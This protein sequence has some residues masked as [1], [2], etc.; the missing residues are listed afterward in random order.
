MNNPMDEFIGDL[1]KQ[2]EAM[3]N[4]RSTWETH[5]RE[6]ADYVFPRGND[7]Q[8][9]RSQGDKRNQK[10]FDSTA[11]LACNRFAAA[12]ESLLTPRA[13]KWHSLKAT[14][15][16]LNMNF[17]VQKW[18]DEAR[19][20]L[21]EKRYSPKANFASQIYECWMS[22][23]SFG[24]AALFVDED[25]E[26]MGIRY[27]AVHL[28]D[29][30]VKENFAGF[31][32]VLHREF[33]LTARQATQNFNKM[34]DN[35]PEKI[36]KCAKDRPDEKFKFIH[37]VKPRADAIYGDLTF[38]GM[39]Y[40]S[41]Y[42]CVSEK[43]MVREGG[44]RT[45]PYAI[46]R[47]NVAPNE[48]YGRSPAMDV[49]PDIK[50][51]NE[52]EKTT[53]RAAHKSVDPPL[54][55]HDDGIL[56]NF[57]ARPGALN[58]GGVDKNGRQ[59]VTPMQTGAN[60]PLVED[61]KNKKRETINQAF[62]VTLFQILVD[63]PR[64]TATEAQIRNQEKGALLSPTMGRQQSEGLGP[65]IERELEIL[66]NLNVLPEVPDMLAET[67]GQYQVQYDSTLT[68]LQRSEETVG[69]QMM[70]NDLMPFAQQDPTVLDVINK[71]ELA[72]VSSEVNGV[73]Y[74][75]LRSPE[76]VDQM[77][78]QRAQAAEQAAQQAAVPE[79]AGAAKDMAAANK[80]NAEAKAA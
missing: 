38:R 1:I 10:V 76:E 22:L 28:N 49:L 34:S 9:T 16:D 80:L 23:G 51:L 43:C 30:Y 50:T 39:K 65:M 40:A 11:V 75:V 58:F 18:F 3:K 66:F 72:R 60:F 42:V 14:N 7:F 69:I 48:V 59:M 41:Y 5:W 71:D 68:R 73:P 74:R 45:F 61:Q 21:F 32:D 78:Q 70:M 56:S 57:N 24:T 2:H 12:M 8:E 52:M 29:I 53:L 67:G 25:E 54:L 17:S 33:T 27:K 37:C 31:I 4:D 63:S 77:R 6:I 64:M 46:F 19:D 35:L 15:R 13:Q 36:K 20:I 47:Y 26:N 44:F 55:L 62:L 79:A